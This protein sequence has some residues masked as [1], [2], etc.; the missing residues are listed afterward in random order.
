MQVEPR[1]RTSIHVSRRLWAK[2]KARATVEDK[3]ASEVVEEA[4]RSYLGDDP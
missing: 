3:I 1:L 2:V 4:L